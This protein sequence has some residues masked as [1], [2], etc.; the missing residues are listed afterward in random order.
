MSSLKTA[1]ISNKNGMELHISNFGATIISLKVPNKQGFL[2]EVVVGLSSPL[3]YLKEQYL[4]QNRCLGSSI[5]RYAG[6]ISGGGYKI[7]GKFFAL[8]QHKAE[9]LHGGFKGFDKQY[10]DFESVERT[11]NP[12]MTL[13]Y[14]SKHLEEGHPGNL[15]V[16]VS[17]QLLETNELTITYSAKTDNPTHVNLTNHSYFNLHG[18][19][20][21]LNHKLQINSERYLEIDVNMMPSGEI[22]NSKNSKADRTVLEN[23]ARDDFNGFD[24]TFILTT[25]KECAR[26]I[27]EETGIEMIVDTNQNTLVV[28]TPKNF[29]GV[30]FKDGVVYDDFPAI[31]FEAQ[32]YP[33]APNH[34]NFPSTLLMPDE[35][36]ENRTCFKFNVLS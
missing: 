36:Y 26:L 18:N 32:N 25:E 30:T 35:I 15:Q 5:G 13:S 29:D 21:I 16:S 2:T 33:D 10:W 19:G 8:S 7:D 1:I 3:D 28:F 12:M 27:S 11:E 24:D 22:L 4:N 20:T 14:V 31:C 9:H 6:R 23:I 17:Y 34:I